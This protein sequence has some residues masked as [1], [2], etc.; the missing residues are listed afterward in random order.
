MCFA[1]QFLIFNRKHKPQSMHQSK[2]IF[3]G[4]IKPFT[5]L[6]LLIEHPVYY[7]MKTLRVV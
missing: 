1:K 6:N 7:E 5:V 3:V 2:G 4:F